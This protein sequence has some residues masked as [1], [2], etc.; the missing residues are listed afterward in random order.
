G[1]WLPEEDGGR[2]DVS[3]V[4]VAAGGGGGRGL[5]IVEHVAAAHGWTLEVD[6][7]PEGGFRATLVGAEPTG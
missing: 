4:G 3:A 6:E 5:A 2:W 7:S 1:P